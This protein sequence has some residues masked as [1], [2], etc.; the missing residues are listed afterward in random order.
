MTPRPSTAGEAQVRGGGGTSSTE[1][2]GS[3]GSP[4]GGAP[5]K[6]LAKQVSYYIYMYIGERE[7]LSL[8]KR[9]SRKIQ[10]SSSSGAQQPPPGG[11][12]PP[13]ILRSRGCEWC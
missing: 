2:E 10:R 4:P 13:Q 5:I 3:Y 6:R 8:L 11:V 9:T 7:S 12:N 1:P